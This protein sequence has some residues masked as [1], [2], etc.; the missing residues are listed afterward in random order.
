M[1]TYTNCTPLSSITI[2]NLCHKI[3]PDDLVYITAHNNSLS[4][5]K[6][7]LSFL[8]VFIYWYFW[9]LFRQSFGN[10]VDHV[11]FVHPS[12]EISVKISV[13]ISTDTRPMYRSTDISADMSV[14]I[15]VDMSTEM[16]RSTY[17][18][19]YQPRY[20]PSDGRHIDRLSADISVDI[21]ADTRPIRWLLIVGGISVDRRWHVGQ[22]LRMLVYKL[23]AFHPFLINLKNFWRLHARPSCAAN[24]VVIK[25]DTQVKYCQIH[26]IQLTG[27]GIRTIWCL[28]SPIH[29]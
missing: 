2:I 9:L 29:K 10:L 28:Q 16:C 22:K 7:F 14:N 23:Y 25:Q 24:S 26:I 6:C 27:K 12:T 17:R 20:R 1:I 13:D 11:Y 19:M 5:L 21:A 18:P 4:E 3:I 8:L 15:S